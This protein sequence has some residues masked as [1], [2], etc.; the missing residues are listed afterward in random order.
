[1]TREERSR[2]LRAI[3][4]MVAVPA[5]M[6]LTGCASSGPQSADSGYAALETRISALPDVRDVKVAG[7]YNGLPTSRNLNLT[8]SVEDATTADLP[9]FV[10][11]VLR[12][13]WAFTSYSP[14]NV[15]IAML[16]ASTPVPSGTIPRPIDLEDAAATLGISH[17][18]MTKDALVVPGDALE[19]LYGPWPG[20]T[21]TSR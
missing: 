12:E 1:M 3:A 17:T 14:K 4:T 6:G 21:P 8:V 15:S 10:D 13:A 11:S 9:G 16:D 7:S 2:V 19:K 18:S 20:P 5:L